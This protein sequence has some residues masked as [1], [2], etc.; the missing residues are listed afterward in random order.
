M[1]DPLVFC[2]DLED[3]P[4]IIERYIDYHK[5][6]KKEAEGIPQRIR[7]AGVDQMDIFITGNRL[8]MVVTVN[9]TYDEVKKAERD[10]SDPVTIRWEALV[11]GLQ[12]ALPWAKEGVKWTRADRIYRL[13]EH[14]EAAK[15]D[16]N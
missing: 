7:D 11:G 13:T 10:A 5:V 6:G 2:C 12:R 3:D 14:L 9:D 4:T 15:E 16:R 1:S 8:I